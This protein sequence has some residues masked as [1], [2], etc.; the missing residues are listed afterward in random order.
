MLYQHPD[1]VDLHK[2]HDNPHTSAPLYHIDP[3]D[4][5]DTLTYVPAT[6][7]DFKKLLE[8]TGDTITGNP[9]QA[10]AEKGRIYHEHLTNRLVEVLNQ[11]SG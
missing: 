5:R 6:R 2:A 9:T 1:L 4:P 8:K 7:K 11:L 10:T 3:G